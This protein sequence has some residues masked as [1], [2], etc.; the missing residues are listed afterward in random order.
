VTPRA[1]VALSRAAAAALLLA[2]VAVI[3]WAFRPGYM[4][5][6]SLTE[7][8]VTKPWG[9][10][11]DWRAPLI[12]KLWDAF[13]TAGV[14]G[15]TVVLVAQTLTLVTGFYLV[16]RAALGRLAAAVVA[17]ALVFTPLVLSQAMLVGRDTWL[18]CFIVFQ[19]GCAVRWSTTTGRWRR[20]W[21]ALALVAGLLALATRQNGAVLEVFV[22]VGMA[23]R[24]QARWR[25]DH[26]RVRRLL[27]PVA[28]GGAACVVGF[29]VVSVV[30]RLM[31]ARDVQPEA[32]LYAY[33]LTG[34]SLRDDEVLIGPDAF[35]AQDLD[36]LRERWDPAMVESVLV[37]LGD[38]PVLVDERFPDAIDELSTDWRDE[39]RDRPG[40]YLAVR[41][42]LFQRIIGTSHA[43]T[44]VVHL[45]VDTNNFG[46]VIANPDANDA[47]RD[48]LG[49]FSPDESEF[50]VGSDLFRPWIWLALGLVA[51]AVLLIPRRIRSRPGALEVGLLLVGGVAFEC[52]YFLLAMGESFRYSYPSV[53]IAVL[54]LV[55]TV[56]TLITRR[57]P[58]TATT[59][60]GVGHADAPDEPSPA[61]PG[62]AA[63]PEPAAEP[64]G[65]A[66]A[67]GRTD[68]I[69]P[70]ARAGAPPDRASAVP[71]VPDGQAGSP[72]RD[73][74][75]AERADA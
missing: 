42:D 66:D 72:V 62:G 56:A 21:L 71:P 46:F 60:T 38:G 19:V 22:L 50:A 8:S 34:M 29:A 1:R 10:F 12:E 33:D 5:A 23:A 54:G 27:V 48:Y 64:G 2:P 4:N 51:A 52:T 18:T 15:P 35:P 61:E 3:T 45:G 26:G 13:E 68:D 49:F 74:P 63:D 20:V 53:V 41:W 44:Y 11:T 65:A 69:R 30:P 70:P 43:P 39:I 75:D 9:D 58:L 55:F 40:D 6:D 36:V 47:F 25:P 24:G 17:A 28:V 32:F 31:G 57:P 16:L 67:A 14:G 7:Y 37:P 73:G 59:D